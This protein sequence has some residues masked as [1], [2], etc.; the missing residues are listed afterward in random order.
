M[1]KPINVKQSWVERSKSGRSAC[2]V[3]NQTIANETVRVGGQ[4]S[5]GWGRFAVSTKYWHLKCWTQSG[6]LEFRGTFSHE[7]KNRIMES[8][9]AKGD[10]KSAPQST[11]KT[12]LASL[13]ELEKAELSLCNHGFS[14]E[15]IN[16]LMPFQRQGVAF[17]L[18]I[19]GRV[20][21]CDEM[22]L[23]KTV[24]GISFIE[25]Y[26]S[27]GPALIITPSSVK[28]NWADELEKW[29]PGIQPGDI[30]IIK[31]RTYPGDLSRPIS[32]ATYGMF[33][34]K[35]VTADLLGKAGFKV[36]VLD[37]SH[38]IK[39]ITAVRS[40][41][42]APILSGANRVALLSG[43][44]ALAKPIELW[45]QVHALRPDLFPNYKNFTNK[46]CA[47]RYMPWGME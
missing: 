10:T 44:P 11:T 8:L 46:F 12:T 28:L 15:Y 2:V 25:A 33:S 47:P 29:L 20:L 31:S 35:S 18:Q 39:S 27:E 41:M 14:Q 45:P 23:G 43:T 17:S 5:G 40:K 34:N 36:V 24:Q 30:N 37:E 32:I 19:E 13:P 22:G 26:K 1:K 4:V 16:K 21:I 7:Q 38:Y 9:G 3:C 6:E 42:I